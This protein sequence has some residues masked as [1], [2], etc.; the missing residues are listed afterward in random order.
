MSIKNITPSQVLNSRGEPTIK[1]K[2]VAENGVVSYFIVPSGVNRG[3]QEVTKKTDGASSYNGKSVNDSVALIRQVI[4]PKFIGY[5]L[6]HQADFD[7]LLVALDSS[8]NKQHLGGNTILAMSGAYFKLS[9]K[10][11]HKPLW[12]EIAEATKSSPKFPRIYANMVGGG[13]HAPGLDIQEFMIVPKA[14][15][16]I[17]AIEQVAQIYH[18]L[19]TIMMSL[20]GPGAKLVGDEGA[21][22]PVGARTEVI[23]EALANLKDKMNNTFDIAL[24]VAANSFFDGKNYNFEDQALHASD[25]L[26]IYQQWQTQFGLYSIED[27]FAATDLEGMELLKTM[28]KEKKPFRIISDDPTVTKA[29]LIDEMAKEKI[30]DGVV[31]KPDQVSTISEMFS[32]IESAKKAGVD[33]IISHRSGESNDDFIV[34]LAYGVGAQGIKIG[35][36]NRGERIAKYNRLLEIQYSLES[37]QEQVIGATAFDTKPTPTPTAGIINNLP[38]KTIPAPFATPA[39][40]TS[41]ANNLPPT[42]TPTPTPTPIIKPFAAVTAQAS[43]ADASSVHI[44]SPS[45]P[46]Q[47]S[48]VLAIQTEE[49]KPP[50]QP[51]IPTISH[52]VAS[53]SET[54]LPSLPIDGVVPTQTGFKN[55]TITLTPATQDATAKE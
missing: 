45:L 14:D 3:A 40:R 26:A 28:P 32:A 22:A 35:A 48:E 10:L 30:F 18:T 7:S 31:I 53:P 5:P 24:D 33:I 55:A 23:L 11:T 46:A 38:A 43:T 2:M 8:E 42:P 34:D 9:A 15:K 17:E 51:T 19:R 20:Y 37:S 36:P 16:P 44:K 39:P 52:V 13:K 4:A 41:L 6:A 29:N 27:P 21:I 50:A 12:Q 54:P 49:P 47:T 25:M 1:V